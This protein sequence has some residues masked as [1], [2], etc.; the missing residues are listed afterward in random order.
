[1]NSNSA[2]FRN[3]LSATRCLREDNPNLAD[4]IVNTLYLH[5]EA[6]ARKTV[7]KTGNPFDW[8]RFLDD[9]LTSPATG[10]PIMLA[11]LGVL[12]WIT[13][14]GANY[15][16]RVLSGW[17]FAL[18]SQ[19]SAAFI[20]FGAPEWLHGVAVMGMFRTFAWVVS[21]MLP[22][23]AIFFPLF[24]FLE[25][26][27]YLPRVAFNL[28][29]AFKCAGTHGKQALT[30]SMGFGCNAAGVTACRIIDSP[31]ER[32]IAMIT[33]NF[34]PCNGRFPTLIILAALFPGTG[35]SGR[36][37]AVGAVVGLV[38]LGITVT[39]AVSYIL[40]KTVLKGVPSTFSLELP[41]YR[42]PQL[43]RILV[44]SFTDRTLFVLKRAIVVAV[45]AGA[46]IWLCANTSIGG[47]NM[48]GH[49]S[50]W[51]DPFG[52]ALGMDG[53]ILLAFILG[54][55]ANEIVVPIII[56]SYLSSGAMLEYGSAESLRQ[57][58][59]SHGWT[60]ATAL[61][62]MLFSLLHFPCATTLW[63]LRAETNSWKWVLFT[64]G[65]TTFIACSTCFIVHQIISL[66]TTVL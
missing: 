50:A 28:D 64:A 23:M 34:V 59:T 5:S 66:V 17:L 51:L 45:P 21:V 46:F 26:L 62:V 9:I 7:K 65:I 30:M 4:S 22:P 12:F 44:T 55:P 24:T 42:P 1:M 10:F 3:I 27:G 57:L 49:L 6:I 40:S 13:L 38:L 47:Q 36:A 54:L 56:M 60:W 33:N 43:G 41:P 25:D 63:T 2:Q 32:L 53:A 11:L 52:R 20:F 18:E 37:F 31:R 35:T 39:L 8:D 58:L 16:S 61:S 15:P 14:V 29:R 19:L 48:M